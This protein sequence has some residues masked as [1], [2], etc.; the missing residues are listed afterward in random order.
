[1]QLSTRSAGP[2]VLGGIA[3]QA[4]PPP[5]PSPLDSPHPRPSLRGELKWEGKVGAEGIQQEE[6][7]GG[8]PT[9]ITGTS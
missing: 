4:Q 1:M 7:G 5:D 8:S 6:G 3:L 2:P 9:N